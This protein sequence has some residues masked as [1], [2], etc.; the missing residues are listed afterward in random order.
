MMTKNYNEPIRINQKPNW[1]YN[2]DQP[3]RILIIGASGSGK[4][5]VLLN[6]IKHQRPDIDVKDLFKSIKVSITYQ[7]KRK[8][9][10]QRNKKIQR[11]LLI[12]YKQFMMSM[13]I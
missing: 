2:P 1:L 4:T 5:N 13:K 10:D 8:C 7:W 6:L 11:H 9:D 12:I 3:Y